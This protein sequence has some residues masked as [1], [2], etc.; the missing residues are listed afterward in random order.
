MGLVHMLVSSTI[1]SA[2]RCLQRAQ[3][4]LLTDLFAG[5]SKGRCMET[6][7][8]MITCRLPECSETPTTKRRKGIIHTS[9]DLK[10][11]TCDPVALTFQL[12]S[13]Y[14]VLCILAGLAFCRCVLGKMA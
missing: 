8:K 13:S 1:Q 14:S 9:G 11:L 10:M 2:R 3:I 4:P 7:T 5:T 12:C 6:F